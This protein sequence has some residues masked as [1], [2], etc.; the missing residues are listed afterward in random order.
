MPLALELNELNRE[1]QTNEAAILQA[2]VGMVPDPPPPALV[3]SSPAGTR[4]SWASSPRAWRSDSTAGDPAE[5]GRRRGQGLRPQHPG[6][7]PARRSESISAYLRRSAAIA[8]PAVCACGATPSPRSARRSSL[9]PRRPRRRGPPGGAPRRRGGRR[10]RAHARAG[11]RARAPGAA[12][13]RQPQVTLLLHAAE[14]VSP[15][16]TRDGRHAQYRVRCD[17]ASCQA[18]H[19]NFDALRISPSRVATTWRSRSP[20]T[21]TTA[22]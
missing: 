1:R 19:F 18:I 8:P 9:R 15:R 21:S 4:A 16:L 10:R 22:P 3:L 6:V 20:R 5:R 17:G 11:R 12:R 14:V 13:V 2:A 7:R